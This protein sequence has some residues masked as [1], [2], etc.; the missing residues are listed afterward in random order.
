MPF[1]KS[2][3]AKRRSPRRVQTGAYHRPSMLN[4]VPLA[5][6]SFRKIPHQRLTRIYNQEIALSTHPARESGRKLTPEN[7]LRAVFMGTPQFA[8]PALDA[9]A[10]NPAVELAAVYT[11]PD[12]RRGRG[13]IMEPSPVKA[14]AQELE[15]PVCQPPTL[16][17]PDA[18][19]ELSELNPE[20]I[21]VVAYGRLLP[22]E[23]LDTPRFGCLNLH[24]SLLPRHR[25]PSPVPGA[26]LAGDETTGISLMLLD[27]GMDTGP[28][29]AQRARAITSEDDAESLTAELFREGAD[30]LTAALPEWLDGNIVPQPQ[31]DAMATYTSRMERADG[32]A[33][34]N[35]TAEYLWR[36]QRAYAPWP[37]L[38]TSWDGQ[39]LKLLKVEP[40][41]AMDV[42]N[43]R[44]Q[45]VGFEDAP[46]PIC[47]SAGEGLLAVHV[48]QLEGR[49]PAAAAD[50]LRGYP[51][52]MGA[53]LG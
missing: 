10:S 20:I 2:D 6:T 48:L 38:H 15:I 17:N 21:V 28:V 31:D 36:Q 32:V 18:I 19:G 34:W 22:A 25:G 53:R 4:C 51:R 52:F 35:S 37:G 49:R 42:M 40:W 5:I 45:V 26:I 3:D 30:L 47:I 44:G 29:I 46:S 16:R 9:L 24:P 11:P 43:P 7:P 14:R 23:V 50:F 39:E 41:D 1:V 8:I 12:R 33:D 13:R 27:E